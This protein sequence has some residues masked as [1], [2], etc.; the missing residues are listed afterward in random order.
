MIQ[1]LPAGAWAGSVV[2]AL[3]VG[4][5]VARAE[6]GV[7][8]L[9]GAGAVACLQGLLTNDLEKPGDG[10]F[11]YGALLTPKGMV[12]VDGWAGRVGDTVR[13]TVPLPGGGPE[14]AR[15]VFTRSIPPRLARS[16]DRTPEL[17][18]LRLTGTHA[19]AIAEA[20][21]VPVPATAGHVVVA[22]LDGM[23]CEIAR[24][25]DGA[26]FQL[27]VT[28][29]TSDA[30]RLTTRLV[31]AGALPAEGRALDLA[32]II[33]GWPGLTSEVDERTLPQEIRLDTIGGVSYTKGCYTGQ[34]TVSRLHFRGH[35]NRGL[36]GLEF[37]AEPA[38]SDTLPIV[39]GDQPVGRVSSVAWLPDGG[40]LGAPSGRWIGL[41]LVRHEVTPGET[42]RV[43]GT[44][45]R[46]VELPFILP[47]W[48]PA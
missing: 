5:L 30:S 29:P 39:H 21:R 26:P 23:S 10:A 1:R 22:M 44:E 48:E 41:G 15:A 3:R 9:V 46:I 16:S 32:R 17:A 25:S 13:F 38:A 4:A 45:A 14:R 43:G 20:A 12:V 24:A 36:V 7:L 40:T 28:A 11:V 6:V 47:R 34:E 35:A 2:Q 27:Q 31:T 37:D 18:V 42:V 33:A 19:L 8:E